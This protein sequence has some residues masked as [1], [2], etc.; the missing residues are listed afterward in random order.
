MLASIDISR[1]Y[2]N[3]A[4]DPFDWPLTCLFHDDRYYVD[5]CMP[6]G[7]RASSYYMQQMAEFIHRAFKARG[8]YVVIY[9]DDAL[10]ICPR[11]QDPMGVF[12]QAITVI[13]ELGLPLA[14][15]K[16]IAPT[17]KIK[18]LGVIIDVDQ[19]EVCIPQAK[20]QQCL[21]VAK[22]IVSQKYISKKQLQSVIG[23]INFIG[24]GVAPARLFINRLL[25]CLRSAESTS[26]KVGRLIREDLNW[27]IRFLPDYNGR[28]IIS[29]RSPTFTIEVDSC[30]SGGE[31]S[32][33]HSAIA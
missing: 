22:D 9:L 30:L 28:S 15:D 5:L 26:I 27:F 16:L 17:R 7:S 6:F 13:R 8:V 32:W 25:H 20:I 29:T 10:F 31:V 4:V 2:R 23:L 24:K 19:R 3:F 18:F 33:A 11:D 1:A 14:W 21:D 12:S